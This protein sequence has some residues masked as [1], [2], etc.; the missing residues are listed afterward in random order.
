MG[1]VHAC[2]KVIP[3]MTDAGDGSIIFISSTS[4]LEYDPTLVYG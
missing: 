2:E 3:W 4:G 1:A